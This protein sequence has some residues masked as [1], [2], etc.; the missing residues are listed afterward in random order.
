MDRRARNIL[1]DLHSSTKVWISYTE[2]TIS[3]ENIV[4][5]FEY[6]LGISNT[7]NYFR[8]EAEPKLNT[9]DM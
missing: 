3:D 1:A 9:R 2:Y 6:I 5:T 7:G 4:D 8:R